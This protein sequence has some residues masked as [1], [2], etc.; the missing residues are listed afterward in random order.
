VVRGDSLYSIAWR[1]ALDYRQ[2]AA[3][4]GINPPY[5]IYVDQHLRLYPQ[6]SA[7]RSERRIPPSETAAIPG[8][9]EP[10]EKAPARAMVAVKTPASKGKRTATAHTTGPHP[11]AQAPQA[12]SGES[13]VAHGTNHWIW[14][15]RGSVVQTFVSGDRTRQGIRIAGHL[16]QDV[17]AAESGRVVYSGSGLPGYGQLIIIKHTKNYLSAYGFNRKLLVRE[18]SRVTRGERVSEMGNSA[19]G[20]PMLHFEIRHGDRVL[21]PMQLLPPQ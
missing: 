17:V 8:P 18:G 5:L 15:T 7:P 11:T 2:L 13:M 16:G 9:P 4:N 10:N 6:A 12:T 20:K 1:Y 3:W 21:D 14:P 19:D